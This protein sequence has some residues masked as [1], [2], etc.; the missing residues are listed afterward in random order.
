ML[1]RGLRTGNFTDVLRMAAPFDGVVVKNEMARRV[2]FER[3]SFRVEA[4][5]S[6]QAE[7]TTQGRWTQRSDLN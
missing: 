5:Y 7:L 2:R 1:L 4:E 3:T 6:I